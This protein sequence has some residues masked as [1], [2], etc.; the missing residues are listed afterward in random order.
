MYVHIIILTDVLCLGVPNDSVTTIPTPLNGNICPT[1]V[2]MTCMITDLTSLRW[3]IGDMAPDSYLY[4]PGDESRVPITISTQLGLL[5]SISSVAQDN[6]NP[7]LIILMLTTNTT[8]LQA[9]NMQD[10]TCGSLIAMSEPVTVNFD[11]LCSFNTWLHN[12]T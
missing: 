10:F 6:V 1:T 9:F 2:Q 7:D 5:I 12:S 3:F 8:L 11:L 4:S